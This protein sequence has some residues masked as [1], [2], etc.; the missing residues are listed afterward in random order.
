MPLPPHHGPSWRPGDVPLPQISPRERALAGVRAALWPPRAV[1]GA[2]I[3]AAAVAGLG[4]FGMLFQATLPARLP[5]ELDWRA[6]SALV[7]RDARPGDVVA[8]SPLWAE[9]A[10]E[11]LPER[12]AAHPESPLVVMAHPRY[13]PEAEDL[14]G[15][16]RVWLVS[17]PEAP[18][19][20]RRIAADL[21][22]RAAAVDGPQ[23]L[24]AIEVTRYDLRSPVLPLAWLPDRLAAANVSLGGQPCALD[25]GGTFRCPAPPWV[26]V[27]RE[28]REIDYL[29]RP[30]LYAHPGSDPGAPLVIEFPDVP[31]GRVLRGHT[32][33]VGEAM[34]AGNAPVRLAVQVDGEEVG[35]AVEPPRTPGWH[36]FQLDTTLHAGR[37][38]TVTFTVTAADPGQRLFCFDAMTLP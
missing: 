34:L 36:T 19:A 29:P 26:H 12:L 4:L 28:V 16:R 25:A 37:G 3:L 5:T 13:R 6:V 15:V 21:A 17:L 2:A 27:S 32:G 24:G 20:S 8:L 18:G 10:R 7:A 38:A 14:V 31:M 9:R 30:C 22:A 23:R 33:I 1:H 35:A 11:V